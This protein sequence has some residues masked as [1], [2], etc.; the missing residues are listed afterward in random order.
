MTASCWV[1]K[2]WVLSFQLELDKEKQKAWHWTAG[3]FWI[4]EII[5]GGSVNFVLLMNVE[6]G[7]LIGRVLLQ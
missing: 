1:W 4:Q 5:Y 3:L 7:L 2:D 6:G